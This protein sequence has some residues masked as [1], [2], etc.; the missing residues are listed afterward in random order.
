[1]QDN[2]NGKGKPAIERRI[3]AGCRAARC[4]EARWA[5][6]SRSRGSS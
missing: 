6:A 5:S 2:G 4:C 3:R 1:M